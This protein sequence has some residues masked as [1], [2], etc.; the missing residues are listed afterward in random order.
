MYVCLSRFTLILTSSQG[1]ISFTLEELDG[2]PSDVISGYTKRSEG[3]K[4]VYDVTYKTPD[5]FP[6]VCVVVPVRTRFDIC[7]L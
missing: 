6:I 7:L 3:S 5:I 2:V 4:E 1:V